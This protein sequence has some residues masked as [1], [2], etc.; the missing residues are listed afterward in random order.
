L[1]SK[2]TKDTLKETVLLSTALLNFKTQ[3]DIK[4]QKKHTMP[5]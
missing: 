1:S 2:P 3:E 4:V 5:A